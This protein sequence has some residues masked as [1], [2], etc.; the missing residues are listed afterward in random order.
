MANFTQPS[1]TPKMH[2]GKANRPKTTDENTGLSAQPR[3]YPITDDLASN[4]IPT[5]VERR[6]KRNNKSGWNTTPGNPGIHTPL[7]APAPSR[8]S[9]KV[10]GGEAEANAANAVALGEETTR[11]HDI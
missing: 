2:V 10:V 11:H 4:S 1:T 5:F 8:G 9:G 3:E 6:S 7:K